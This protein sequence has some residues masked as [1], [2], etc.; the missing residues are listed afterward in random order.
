MIYTKEKIEKIRTFA[1]KSGLSAPAEFFESPAEELIRVC[2]GIGSALATDAA[3][4]RL[5]WSF[6]FAE[7]SAAIHDWRYARSDGTEAGRLAA[8]R[9]FRANMLDEIARRRPS[10]RWLRE[11]QALRLY[12]AAREYGRAAWCI[13]F[14]E[15]AA[16][17]DV[18]EPA[19]ET[20][21]SNG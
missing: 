6:R 5:T 14:A 18:S 2:N 8:D 11:W 12:N 17:A 16:K 3:R 7:C 21:A 15:S 20:E 9:E 1:K 4:R 10:W 13:A 19:K